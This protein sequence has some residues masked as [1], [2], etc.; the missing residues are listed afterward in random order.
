LYIIYSEFP[1]DS[2]GILTKLQSQESIEERV[3]KRERSHR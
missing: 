2:I 1:P 3:A